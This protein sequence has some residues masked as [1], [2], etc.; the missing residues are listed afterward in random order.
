MQRV[1]SEVGFLGMPNIAGPF[2]K[3]MKYVLS[4]TESPLVFS[5]MLLKQRNFQVITFA[6]RVNFRLQKIQ[7]ALKRSV[8]LAKLTIEGKRLSDAFA[9]YILLFLFWETI[10]DAQQGEKLDEPTINILSQL[11]TLYALSI[12]S[13]NRGDFMMNGLITSSNLESADLELKSLLQEVAPHALSLSEAFELS[14]Y[15]INSAIAPASG[16]VYE[17]IMESTKL[18]PMNSSIVHAE[19]SGLIS[20]LIQHPRSSL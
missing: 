8:P 18:E 14:E 15:E 4:P 6:S 2:I 10:E 9:E 7:E 17:S 3:M 20:K 11:C 5:S 12:V 16:D 13:E 19:F 1:E